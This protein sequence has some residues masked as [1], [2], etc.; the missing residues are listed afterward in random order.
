MWVFRF[1]LCVRDVG[2]ITGHSYVTYGP[3]AV[4]ATQVIFEGV[5]TYPD[6]SRFWQIIEKHKI[7]IFYTAP[8]AIR[9]CVGILSGLGAGGAYLYVTQLGQLKEPDTRT[10]FFF[11]LISTLGSGMLLINQDIHTPVISDFY[12]LLCLGGSATIAQIA[13]TRAYLY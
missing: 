2:W 3:T 12:I 1:L 11:T 4:G 7:S 5:P 9:G 6:A 10:V 13:I 8:T